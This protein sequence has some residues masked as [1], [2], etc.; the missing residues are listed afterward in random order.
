M[1]GWCTLI[2]NW[3]QRGS[4]WP[5]GTVLCSCYSNLWSCLTWV[6]VLWHLWSLHLGNKPNEKWKSV[7]FGEGGWAM[8][9]E[10][11][12]D[13]GNSIIFAWTAVPGYWVWLVLIFIRKEPLT[14]DNWWIYVVSFWLLP[15]LALTWLLPIYCFLPLFACPII[16]AVWLRQRVFRCYQIRR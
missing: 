14:T 1:E 11:Q 8:L 12:P 3:S 2:K 15:S 10:V 9:H 16:V 4:L 6:A 5:E 13:P 7:A